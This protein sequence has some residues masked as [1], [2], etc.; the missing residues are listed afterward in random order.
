MAD[1]RRCCRDHPLFGP[2]L[3]VRSDGRSRCVECH[4]EGS[5]LERR[6]E[7]L[8]AVVTR[9]WKRCAACHASLPY[10]A[11]CA[12]EGRLR[13]RR[14]ALAAHRAAGRNVPAVT[15][16]PTTWPGP[17]TVGQ[18]AEALL[19]SE[20]GIRRWLKD[21]VIQGIRISDRARWRI[22][23]SEIERVLSQ[24]SGARHPAH[25]TAFRAPD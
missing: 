19:L 7:R 9:H 23:A 21:G 15:A 16:D 20:D 24:G 1:R 14:A 18:A 10:E 3:Q 5:R 25:P 13:A 2:N 22:R 4:R 8:Q 17:L 12:L 11:L 6:V